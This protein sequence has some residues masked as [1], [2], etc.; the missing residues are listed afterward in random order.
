MR[1]RRHRWILALTIAAAT[2]LVG[3]AARAQPQGE[4]RLKPDAAPPARISGR[5]NLSG[6][7]QALNTAIWNLEAHSA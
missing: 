7:W 5:P 3:G 4:V 2:A 1:P 6:I